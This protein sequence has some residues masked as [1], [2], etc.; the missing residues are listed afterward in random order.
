MA[1]K[2]TK[3]NEEV[4]GEQHSKSIDKFNKEYY[5]NNNEKKARE[6]EEEDNDNILHPMEYD[7]VKQ[8]KADD[9][10]DDSKFSKLK[11][12]LKGK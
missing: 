2:T 4:L 10:R 5:I 6:L 3:R 8:R 1:S 11:K 7:L 12:L 9:D